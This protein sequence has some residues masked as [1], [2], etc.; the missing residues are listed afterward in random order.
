MDDTAI[1]A[2]VTRL[3]R[4]HGSGG[5]V[6]ERAAIFAAGAHSAE[7]FAWIAAHAGEPE[8][9]AATET[10]RGLHSARLSVPVAKGSSTPQRYV[11]PPGALS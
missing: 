3:S 10:R 9:V 11:L 6:I 1:R 7:V 5:D 4:P 2:L 8:R